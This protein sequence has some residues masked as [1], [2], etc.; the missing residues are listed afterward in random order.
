MHTHIN[1]PRVPVH[2]VLRHELLRKTLHL[3]AWLL[4]SFAPISSVEVE[5]WCHRCARCDSSLHALITQLSTSGYVKHIPRC[6]P[7]PKSAR[8]RFIEQFLCRWP[9]RLTFS[10]TAL[11]SSKQL[12]STNSVHGWFAPP[13]NLSTKQFQSGRTESHSAAILAYTGARTPVFWIVL[14]LKGQKWIHL[15]LFRSK[16]N[17]SLHPCPMCCEDPAW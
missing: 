14:S 6:F 4:N 9:I 8:L 17:L 12:E 13:V 2:A 3:A 7:Y 11:A 15:N 1:T 10:A 16:S 5:A